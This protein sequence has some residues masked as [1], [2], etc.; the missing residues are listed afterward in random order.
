MNN[1]INFDFYT[2]KIL[3]SYV[4]AL[5]DPAS[6]E[7]FY[8]GKGGGD[9]YG[10]QRIFS[11]FHE[12]DKLRNSPEKQSRKIKK[13]L[14]IWNRKQEV[15]WVILRHGLNSTEA[16]EVEAAIIDTLNL[17]TNRLLNEVV[18]HHSA[19]GIL[20]FDGIKALSAPPVRPEKSIKVF[21]FQIHNHPN[22]AL[23]CN[24]TALDVYEATR[25]A[26]RIGKQYRN[27]GDEYYAV[28]VVQGISIGAYKIEDWGQDYDQPTKCVFWKSEE[29]DPLVIKKLLY[30]NWGKPISE[31]K[32]F[33]QHGG[34]SILVEF[35]EENQFRILKGTKDKENNWTDCDGATVTDET[36]REV[37]AD[38]EVTWPRRW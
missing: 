6:N 32:G 37:E 23:N 36:G 8:V 38:S 5:I 1:I 16:H 14:D 26:W 28:G 2:L 13:I 11:H 19:R 9:A 22:I 10:N 24:I 33:L 29:P 20:N 35:N 34:G 27:K 7:I 25:R 30:K 12:A 17:P 18:G 3:R 31:A 21:V 4:Y 15:K